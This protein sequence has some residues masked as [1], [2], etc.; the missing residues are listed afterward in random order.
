[1]LYPKIISIEAL[2]EYK[3]KLCYE[4]GEVKIFDALPYM[5]GKW[6]E[7]LYNKSYFRSVRLLPD[8][9]GIEW[10]H[11]QDIAPHELYDMS[12]SSDN[13]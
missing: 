1:M 9:E 5:S 11:G 8:R 2:D 7:E 12:I 10:A 13:L 6:Y 3:I 4:T